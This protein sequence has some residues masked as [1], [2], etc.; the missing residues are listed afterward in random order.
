[1]GRDE[2]RRATGGW[3]GASAAAPPTAL[4]AVPVVA[5]PTVT[6]AGAAAPHAAVATAATGKPV[7]PASVREFYLPA[8]GPVMQLTPVLYGAARVHYTDTKRNID[9]V[10][11]LQ[12]TVPFGDGAVAIDWDRAEPHDSTPDDLTSTP[13]VL[14]GP[15]TYGPLPP[16]GRDPKSYT[17][18]AKDFEQWIVR[19]E[20]LTVYSAPSV[21]LTSQAGESERDF[22][23]RVQQASRE[24]RDAAVQKLR[25]SYAPKVARLT[26]RVQTA[27]EAVTREE[28]QAAAQKTQTMVSTGAAVLGALFGRKAISLSNL[29]RATTA[30]RGVGR[31]MKETEDIARAQTK[32]QGAEAELKALEA[33]IAEEI[34]ALN[35]G[36]G[37]AIQLDTIEIRPK[38]GS[39]DVRL[40]A[41]AWMAE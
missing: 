24:S 1:M 28:Q 15:V 4:A 27:A 20:R 25:D 29:G 23:V 13:P 14:P 10:Q 35:A 36:D 39:V 32:Q 3:S 2:I 30:A 19:A 34:A 21:K 17:A 7:L 8:A 18:W 31:A 12:V 26:Q 5:S 11:D 41:L 40:V 33:E 6:S 38:R 9:T 22:R 16:A 37:S